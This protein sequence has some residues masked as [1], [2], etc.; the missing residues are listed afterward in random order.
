MPPMPQLTQD[1]AS[2]YVADLYLRACASLALFT[3][4]NDPVG[5]RAAAYLI[6]A[7]APD[8]EARQRLYGEEPRP[9]LAREGLNDMVTLARNILAGTAQIPTSH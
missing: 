8:E 9:L 2:R 6:V 5:C 3:Q 1:Q 7:F 4:G